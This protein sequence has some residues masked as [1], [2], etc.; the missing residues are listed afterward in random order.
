MSLLTPTEFLEQFQQFSG[1]D[2]SHVQN[3]LDDADVIW[4]TLSKYTVIEEIE[5]LPQIV[6]NVEKYYTAH[7][8]TLE[9]ARMNDANDDDGT[10]ADLGLVIGTEIASESTPD[11]TT[12]YAKSSNNFSLVKEEIFNQTTALTR[13]IDKQFDAALENSYVNSKAFS[14]CPT[15]EL[16]PHFLKTVYGQNLYASVITGYRL[17][18]SYLKAEQQKKEAELL[19][20]EVDRR[21]NSVLSFLIH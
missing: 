14:F 8:L 6:K 12:T 10:K 7:M 13:I 18:L 11:F 1:I 2:Q 19:T 21:K 16:P 20:A 17:I 5:L 4:A 3:L 15:L 9:L